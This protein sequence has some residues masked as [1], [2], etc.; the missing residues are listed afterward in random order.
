MLACM[1]ISIGHAPDYQ[2]LTALISCSI[3]WTVHGGLSLLTS[4]NYSDYPYR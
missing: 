4:F 2:S 3:D 1:F